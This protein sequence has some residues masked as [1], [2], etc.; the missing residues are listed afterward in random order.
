MSGPAP[1][2]DGKKRQRVS[3]ACV[4]CRQRRI[5]VGSKALAFSPSHPPSLAA[6]ALGQAD[7]SEYS[8]MGSNP[9]AVP[10]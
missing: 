5:R 8:A 7:S 2:L 10:A 6:A 1:Q 9:S 4:A 3:I